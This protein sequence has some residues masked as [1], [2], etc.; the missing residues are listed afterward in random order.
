MIT[1]PE[2]GQ[3]IMEC[4]ADR[5]PNAWTCIRLAAFLTINMLL[6]GK[7]EQLQMVEQAPSLQGASFDAGPPME[8]IVDY[9]SG[10]EFGKL[11]DGKRAAQIWPVLDELMS[12]TH[13]LHPQ[14][15]QAVMNKIK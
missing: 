10:T 9:Q 15:Y 8:E 2:I 4:L 5:D 12:I 13:D 11:I 6:Y 14:I 1:E 7:P 3:A